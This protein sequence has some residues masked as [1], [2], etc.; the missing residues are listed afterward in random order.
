MKTQTLY[1]GIIAAGIIIAVVCIGMVTGFPVAKPSGS[2]GPVGDTNAGDRITSPGTNA[3]PAGTGTGSGTPG[4]YI[5]IDPLPD[6]TTGD[7]LIVN[8]TT[9][10]PAGTILLVATHG[11]AGD[12]IVRPGT[13]GVNRFSSPL[14]TTIMSPGVLKVTVLQ[15]KGDPAQG[16]YGPGIL[17]ATSTFTLNGTNRVAEPAVQPAAGRNDYIRIDAIGTR[18]AGDQ[19]LVTGT[20]SLPAGTS[21]LWKV[22]PGNLAFEYPTGNFFRSDPDQAGTYS[23]MIMANSVVTKGSDAANR[24]TY[25]LDTNTLRPGNYTAEAS[26][27]VGDPGLHETGEPS[28]SVQFTVQ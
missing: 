21:I 8:G 28:G 12:T 15:M 22:T 16:D 2:A 5:R 10:L 6:R 20:T 11:V 25:A 26:L 7:L 4:P 18:K 9:N 19:F 14:D 3:L 17:N 27:L 24:V 1:G 23:D 13:G